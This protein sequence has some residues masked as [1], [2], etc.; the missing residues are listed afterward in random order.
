VFTIFI[1]LILAASGQ[2]QVQITPSITTPALDPLGNELGIV[3]N[4]LQ[5]GEITRAIAYLDRLLA[6][7]GNDSRIRA[8]YK[9]AYKEGKLYSNLEKLLK[10]DLSNDPQ[11]PY[12]LTELGEA[13]F[14]QNDETAA[15]S[16]WNLAIK[17]GHTD[18]N[19]Y[20]VV[21][22]NMMQYGL[23]PL[24]V[25]IYLKGRQN[26][27]KPALFSIELGNLFETERDYP[28][29]IDEFLTQLLEEP[30]QLGFVTTKIRGY[31]EDSED[32]QQI[33]DV[34]LAKMK[35]NPNRLELYEVL[36]DLYIKQNQMDKALECYKTIGTKQNDDGG[37]LIK[38]A[39]RSYDSKAYT[40][41]IGAVDEYLK[42]TKKGTAKEIGFLI[43]AKSLAAMGQIDP[44]ISEFGL[45][46]SDAADNRIKDEAG[47]QLG[48]LYAQYK[49][50]CDS[51]LIAWG[52]MQKNTS[53]PTIQN[54]TWI[55]MAVC[56]LKTSNLAACE[57]LLKQVT[58]SGTADSSMEKAYFLLG[59]LALYK[60]NFTDA[61]DIFKKLVKQFPQGDYTNDALIRFDVISLCGD[62]DS[63]KKLLS[64]FG[65]AMKA[66]DMGRP[67][68]AAAI[69][70]D[71]IMGGS[72]IAEQAAF[73]AATAY[74]SG[75][76]HENA[77]KAFSGYIEKFPDGLY[78]DR[79]YLGLGDLYMQ[80]AATYS[81]AKTAYDKILEAFPNGPV[82]EIARQ[83]LVQLSAPG[84]IG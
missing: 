44:A 9:V 30:S 69:L 50:N 10:T 64:L 74:A 51:A 20:R 72:D 35:E 71:S 19:V 34:V 38:F 52:K 1:I 53:E 47:F 68:E 5:M 31:I 41:A 26:L 81:S 63:N 62:K 17:F 66:Q 65:Q 14:L 7:Y 45:L 75:G 82:T 28:K 36:G 18:E 84:K 4:L 16:L 13:K 83:R 61:G 70:S 56:D 24:A 78:I 27:G 60:E 49:N 21:A 77:I 2:A 40:A 25:E 22:D 11:N 37:A 8:F 55:E 48:L 54:R 33:V 23:Y 39:M 29:A 57:T 43:K 3:N 6:T 58:S 12:I 80:D 42:V 73:Y 67:L 76:S 59:E 32:P 79:T 15:D 46:A